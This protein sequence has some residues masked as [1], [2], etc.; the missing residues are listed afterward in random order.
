MSASPGTATDATVPDT[1]L[2]AVEELLRFDGPV[3]TVP[4]V[5]NSDV[6]VAGRIIPADSH[7]AVAIA[8]ANRDPAGHRAPDTV[9]FRRDERHL[10]FGAGPHGCLGA[11]LARIEMRVVLTE[12]HRR[13]PD[14]ELAP[15]A[16]A[17]A[18]WPAGLVGIDNLPLVFPPGG[19]ETPIT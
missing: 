15:G 13:I 17:R 6:E 4:R 7:V 8:T 11:H 14:Y 18:A 19:R 5:A 9:D 12:W 2:R 10:A 3:V 16:L 1:P